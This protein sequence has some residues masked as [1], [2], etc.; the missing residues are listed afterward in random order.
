[1]AKLVPEHEVAYYTVTNAAHY[2]G[3]VALLDSLRLLGEKAPFF[4]VDCGLTDAQR[5][6]ISG[7]AGLVQPVKGVHPALQKATGPLAHPAEIMVVLDADVIV[8][9]TLA[10]LFADAAAGR[11]V[12]FEERIETRFCPEWSALG[13]GEPVRRPYVSSGHFVLSAETGSAFFPLFVELQKTLEIGRTFF[14][15]PTPADPDANPYF[16]ADQDIFNAMLCTV[17]ADDVVRLEKRLWSYPPFTGLRLRGFD[18][19]RCTYADG[20]SP[21]LLHH[22]FKKPWL[23]PLRPSI[24]SELFTSLTSAPDAPVRLGRGDVPLR[25]RDSPFAPVDRWRASL[26]ESGHRRLRGKLGIRRRLERRSRKQLAL[27][28]EVKK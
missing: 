14:G 27:E 13:I 26:Q 16:Y 2:P 15:T 11:I 4:V 25:L 23:T 10:P 28:P 1:M 5:A 17:F 18:G 12:A 20:S 6:A 9:R 24:Y 7:H 21:L 22:F 19:P 3:A 8:N